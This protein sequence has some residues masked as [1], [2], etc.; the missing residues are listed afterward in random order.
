MPKQLLV[1][2]RFDFS[3]GVNTAR[4]PDALSPNELVQATNCRL[5]AVH[6]A[7]SKRTGSRRMH[8]SAIGSGNPVTGLFQWDNAGTNQLV[9]ICNGNLYHK[10]T[11]YGAFTEVVPGT[12]FS[13]TVPQNFATGRQATSGAPLRLYI[14]DG[15]YQRWTGS[16]ISNLTGVSSVPNGDLLA[17]YHGRMFTRDTDFQLHAFWSVLGDPEDHTAAI[18]VGAGNGL[19]NALRG[20][21]LVQWV[22]VGSSLLIATS[23]SI[24]RFTGYSSEDIQIFQDTEG[25]DSNIGA[26]SPQAFIPVESFAALLSDR[27][28]YVVDEARATP[29]GYKVEPSF[30]A[31]DRAQL[32]NAVLGYHKGRREIWFAVEGADD[33]GNQTVWVLSMGAVQAWQGP[34][35]YPFAITSLASWED[36]NGDEWIIAGCSDGFVRHLDTGALDDVLSTGTGGSRYTM[37]VEL[38]PLFFD[39]GPHVAK[40]LDAIYLQADLVAGSAVRVEY[41]FDG[42][43]WIQA[44][45]LWKDYASLVRSYEMETRPAQG[46]RLFVRLV[47]ASSDI[48]IVH[49]LTAEA[50][51]MV[52]RY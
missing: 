2:H 24:V 17:N 16:A 20:E 33:T 5:G 47:D 35:T 46:R 18:G 8:P 23:D 45:V 13:T 48:N 19:V 29:V 4:S 38:P 7:L 6:G 1:E 41:R 36:S 22:K 25:V 43:E 14:A 34:F 30:A 42:G 51:D 9:A 12:A 32:G 27:G 26:I 3:G 50:F 49:G 21:A 15:S 52:R 11:D 39:N 10:T 37:T 28:P 40:T 31:L 44:P